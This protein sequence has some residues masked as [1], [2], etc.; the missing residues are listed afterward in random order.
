[1]G[2]DST[3]ACPEPQRTREEAVPDQRSVGG[4]G[5]V[6]QPPRQVGS[7]LLPVLTLLS[8][9]PG[10]KG[11]GLQFLWSEALVPWSID[12]LRQA[13]GVR[14]TPSSFPSPFRFQM[15][16]PW[17]T[18]PAGQSRGQPEVLGSF[19]E[20]AHSPGSRWCGG[21]PVPPPACC[22]CSFLAAYI[23]GPSASLPLAAFPGM[24]DTCKVTLNSAD[25]V[26]AG[27]EQPC[28]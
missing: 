10:K 16:Q 28:R 6:G 2:S 18:T 1:M 11:R 21:L 5:K 22:S 27:M 26:G 15:L 9:F 7:R 25:S 23:S 20:P 14:S 17:P 4:G 13:A 19:L 12:A 3:T 24:G 8:S